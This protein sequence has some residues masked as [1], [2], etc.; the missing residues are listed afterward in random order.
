MRQQ[1]RRNRPAGP[2]KRQRSR[3][4]GATGFEDPEASGSGVADRR[5]D[6]ADPAT[7]GDDKQRDVSASPT[8]TD[9]AIRS[10]A[11]LAIDAGDTARARALLDLLDAKPKPAPVLTLARKNRTGGPR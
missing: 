9:E 10:A 4:V 5:G 1:S 2:P 6:D 3:V 11:K 7:Q 8:D